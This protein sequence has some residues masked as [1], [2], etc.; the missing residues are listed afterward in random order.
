MKR[1][2]I[3]LALLAALASVY[4]FGEIVI[5][6]GPSCTSG[7]GRFHCTCFVGETCT[8]GA[9]YCTCG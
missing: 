8:A 3:K 2:F 6:N 1:L 4:S 5:I 7:D 9:D